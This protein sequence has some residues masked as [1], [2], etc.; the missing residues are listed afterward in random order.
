MSG[1]N[2]PVDIANRACD[3]IGVEL[4]D[5]AKGFTED[6]KAARRIGA[7]YDKLRRSELER[8]LWRSTIRE[9]ILRAI[10]DDTMFLAPSLWVEGTT[11][12]VGSIVAD[13]DGYYWSSVL[14]NNLGNQP[15]NTPAWV[16]YCGPRTADLYDDDIAYSS[17]EIVYLAPGDGTNRVYVSRQDGNADNPA[18]ATAWA[19]TVTYFKNQVV[20]Y[21]AV[22]Y[23]SLIDLNKNQTP[24]AAP[25]L[26]D[27]AH[28][29]SIG[30][31]VGA[32]DGTIY[33][34]V[35]N[36]NVGNDP[37][38]DLGTNWTNT[39]VLNPWTTVFIGGTG[40]IK[41]LQIGGSGFPYGVTLTTPNIVYPIGSGPASQSANRNVFRLPSNYLRY[42]PQDPKAGSMSYLGVPGN[43]PV[44]DWDFQDE[45]IVSRDTGTIRLRF[46]ADIAD[47]RKMTAM[48]CEGLGARIGLEVCEPITQSNTKIATIAQ[49]YEKFIGDARKVNAIELGPVEPP[50]DD[51]IACRA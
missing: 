19:A 24:S 1:F 41:W 22:A 10:D 46:G 4:I 18:T 6:S 13:E 45:F 32:S 36:A 29:Y 31:Q 49:A 5:T 23:M 7:V 42:A 30:N 25:A 17:G 12:F 33:T 37:T 21:S 2:A 38:L 40:S 9:A 34:S 50:L 39:G 3:H 20:T 11:Y 16:P 26:F 47:V 28:S 8:N 48:F 27:I 35:T 14:P 15:Q 44:D 43:R 51:F